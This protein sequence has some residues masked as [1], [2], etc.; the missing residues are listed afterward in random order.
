MQH[1]AGI[2]A[3]QQRET[4]Q[5]AYLASKEAELKHY[6][7]LAAHSVK[8][9]YE[10]GRTDAATQDEAKRILASLSFGEY[11]PRFALSTSGDGF[12]PIISKAAFARIE[13]NG[14]MPYGRLDSDYGLANYGDVSMPLLGRGNGFAGRFIVR[15]TSTKIP[16]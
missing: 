3:R 14:T 15:A 8:R 16:Q 1:Q 2:L 9:L 11:W 13:R 10:S 12:P 5:Q 6:V 7:A 4:I